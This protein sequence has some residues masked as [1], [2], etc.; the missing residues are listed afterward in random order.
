MLFRVP[1]SLQV[2]S[3]PRNYVLVGSFANKKRMMA[4]ARLMPPSASP[5]AVAI[6]LA[7]LLVVVNS[8]IIEPRDFGTW[9]RA[10]QVYAG[11]TKEANQTCRKLKTKAPKRLGIRKNV[12]VETPASSLHVTAT[13]FAPNLFVS[14][15]AT[16]FPTI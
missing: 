5:T 9:E 3:Y 12:M 15:P 6:V 1:F 16:K 10:R 13:G 4:A 8:D 7:K 2:I 11:L 14:R